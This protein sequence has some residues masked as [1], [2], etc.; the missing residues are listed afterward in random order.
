[1]RK[2]WLVAKNEYAK[3]VRKRSFLLGTLALPIFFIGIM[4]LSIVAT[5]GT[6]QQPVGYVDQAGILSA[7]AIPSANNAQRLKM[8]P[9]VDEAAA[10]TALQNKQIQAFAVVPE[11]YLQTGKI[12][13]YG[14]DKEPSPAAESDFKYFLRANLVAGLPQDVRQRALDGINLTARSAD[15]AQEINGNAIINFILPF[16]LGFFFIIAVMNSATYLLQAIADEKENRTIEVMATSLSPNQLIGGKALG[17]IGVALTQILILCL[18]IGI[19]LGI[20]SN[21]ID[22]LRGV[23]VPWSMLGVALLFFVPAYVLIAGMMIAIGAAVTEVRQ[24]QQL[25]GALN[26]LYTIPYFFVV[27]FMTNPNSP[28]STILTLFPTTA[29][30]TITLRWGLSTIPIWELIASWIILTGTA[31][32]SIWAAARV[33]RTGMLRYGQR[34]NFRAMLSAVRVKAE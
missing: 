19:G 20:G 10:R 32:L 4:V 30:V 14:W 12:T 17:L 33:F 1:M 29:F 31:I 16:A 2:L 34:L 28:L 8:L 26:M 23:R 5:I 7:D 9:F 18:T 27:I 3:I 25:A 13:A 22:F 6:D 11:D 21:S 24:G 15:G